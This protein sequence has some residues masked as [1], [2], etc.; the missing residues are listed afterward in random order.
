M[1]VDWAKEVGA[2]TTA[3]FGGDAIYYPADGSPAFSFVGVFDEAYRE[4]FIQDGLTYTSDAMPVIGI[5]DADFTGRWPTQSGKVRI[6]DPLSSAFNKL[7]MVKE[8]RP[9]SHGVTR[10]VMQETPE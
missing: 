6:M 1:A 4:N 9:D 8:V 7:F 10:L 2:P 3:V 5:L